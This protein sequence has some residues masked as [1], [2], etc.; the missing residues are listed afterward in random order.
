[1]IHNPAF[2]NLTLNLVEEASKQPDLSHFTFATLKNP[3]HTS[4]T[5]ATPHATVLFAS[6]EQFKNNKAQT[7][8]I[9]H[10]A[11]GNYTGHTLYQER[12]NKPSDE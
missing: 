7:A 9:Y 10:D 2:R 4:H 3:T 8:H 5:D 1:R 12:D 11:D 6:E